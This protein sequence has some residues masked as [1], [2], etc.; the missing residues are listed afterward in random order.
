MKDTSKSQIRIKGVKHFTLILACSR[1]SIG[2]SERKQ[3]RAKKQASQGERAGA[4]GR[5]VWGGGGSASYLPRPRH[6]FLTV[7]PHQLRVWNRLP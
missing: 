1:L 3:R 5:G 6:F 2:G 4:R 7:R